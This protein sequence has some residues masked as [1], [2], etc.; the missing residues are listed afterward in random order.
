MQLVGQ[1]ARPTLPTFNAGTTPP[2]TQDLFGGLGVTEFLPRYASLVN[3]GYVFGTVY[4]A[5]A[6]AAASATSLGSFGFWNKVGSGVNVV[7]LS[8]NV[9]LINTTAVATVTVAGL[10]PFPIQTPSA[11]SAG[12]APQNAKLGNGNASQV[13]IYTAATI[14]GGSTTAVRALASIA[15]DLTTGAQV[16]VVDPIDGAIIIPPGAGFGVA[17]YSGTAADTTI[18]LGLMWAEIPIP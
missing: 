5:A 12:N 13:A 1:V 9:G 16:G 17:G 18:S 10:T 2:A 11:V 7:L 14:V 3:A 15:Q 6:L 4:T 8:A